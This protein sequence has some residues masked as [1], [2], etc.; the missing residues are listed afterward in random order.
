[1]CIVACGIYIKG[2]VKRKNSQC[3]KLYQGELF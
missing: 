2:T 3:I 1:M